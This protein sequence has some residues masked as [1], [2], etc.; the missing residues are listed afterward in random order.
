M[1][2]KEKTIKSELI[3]EGRV[4]NLYKDTVICPNGLT[5]IREVVS[6]RGGVG[7]LFKIDDKFIMEKQFRYALNEEIYEIP[8]GKL[9]KDEEP[10]EA[11]KW[12]LLE[13]TGYE[14][15]EMIF[16]GDMYPT[17]GYSSEII[18]LFYC[19]K[20]VKK[21]RHLD[22]DENIDLLFLSLSEIEQL[23]NENI[24]KDSKSIAAVHLYKSKILKD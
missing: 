14:P 23:I 8:A 22:N 15:L 12:E 24:I 13:E 9:E 7:I 4:L 20:A 5:S 19:E 18:H 17:C 21:E 2:K 11:A 6:H 10:L 16:L 3:Y 1:D